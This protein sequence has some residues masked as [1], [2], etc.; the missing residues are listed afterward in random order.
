MKM[1]GEP[2]FEKFVKVIIEGYQKC[3]EGPCQSMDEHWRP[4]F[5]A[6]SYCNLKYDFISKV[7][8]HSI[9]LI[10]KECWI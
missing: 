10:K 8:F 2:S 4:Y 1:Y 6:C 7:K 9:I 3:H 5:A